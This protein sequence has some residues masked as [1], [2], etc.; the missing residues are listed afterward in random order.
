MQSLLLPSDQTCLSGLIIPQPQI[1]SAG[2]LALTQ[3]PCLYWIMFSLKQNIHLPWLKSSISSFILFCSWRKQIITLHLPLLQLK[4][5][6]FAYSSSHYFCWLPLDLLQLAC[7]F[8]G[9]VP[10]D[11]SPSLSWAEGCCVRERPPI[12]P[13]SQAG[14]FPFHTTTALLTHAQLVTSQIIF[15]SI[16]YLASCSLSW[17]PAINYSLH[18]LSC[19]SPYLSSFS[20]KLHLWL[21]R[22]FWTLSSSSLIPVALTDVMGMLSF[23]SSLRWLIRILDQG[24]IGA[25]FPISILSSIVW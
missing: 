17:L 2:A 20:P 18:V 23:C 4:F 10:T 13:C 15:C 12:G 21:K 19:V 14:H 9:S 25:W 3:L 24:Q 11:A 8:Q 22:P 6:H 7:A 16:C 1:S 5:F